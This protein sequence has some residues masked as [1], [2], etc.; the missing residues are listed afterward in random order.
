MDARAARRAE[1]AAAVIDHP[2][3]FRRDGEEGRRYAP[4]LDGR[5]LPYVFGNTTASFSE[6]TNGLKRTLTV[7]NGTQSANITLLGNYM[8]SAF[9][10]A[11]DGVGGTLY[12]TKQIQRRS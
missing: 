7:T 11:A 10:T 9:I 5:L 4:I 1:V 6:N 2:L 3:S 8:A 12:S